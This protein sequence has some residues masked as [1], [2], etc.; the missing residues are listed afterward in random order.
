VRLIDWFKKTYSLEGLAWPK[1]LFIGFCLLILRIGDAAFDRLGNFLLDLALVSVPTL[2]QRIAQG[3][4]TFLFYPLSVNVIT[5]LIAVLV[6]I[7]LY[8]FSIRRLLS[9]KKYALIFSD[10][11][12]TMSPYHWQG[13][14]WGGDPSTVSKKG[15]YL[16]FSARA[17]AWTKL[18][19]N[20]NGALIDLSSNIYEGF[21]YEVSCKVKADERSTMGF[22]LWVHDTK[23]ENS[24]TDPKDFVTPGTELKEYSVK[25]KATNSNALRIHLHCKAGE[26]R[27]LVKEVTI[28]KV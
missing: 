12:N 26:G 10:D 14:Y 11:F 5:I 13:P 16:I 3:F 22:K 8:H 4:L 25:F 20:E 23:G 24:T 6:F 1:V 18:A 15:G 19:P 21:V 7:P 28:I 27:I 9:K 17:G 2:L